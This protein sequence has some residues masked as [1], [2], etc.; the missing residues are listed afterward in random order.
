MS[1]AKTILVIG[2]Y[3]TKDDE[4]NFLK[5]VIQDQGGQVLTMDVSVLARRLNRQIIQ[6][7]TLPKKQVAPS[8]MLSIAAMKITPC[9]SWRK[10]LAS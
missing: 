7:M 9:R 8:R 1:G 4:L 3:D 6:N 2:T 5:S 10:V